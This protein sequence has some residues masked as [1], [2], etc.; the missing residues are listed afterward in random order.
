MNGGMQPGDYMRKN[1]FDDVRNIIEGGGGD[2]PIMRSPMDENAGNWDGMTPAPE[3]A[4]NPGA[5]TPMPSVYEAPVS[6]YNG[7]GGD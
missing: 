5:F 6:P 7:T 2:T 4:Y 1:E 3:T